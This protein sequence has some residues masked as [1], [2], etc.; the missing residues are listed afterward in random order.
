MGHNRSRLNDLAGRAAEDAVARA[1]EARGQRVLGRRWR[2]RGGEI[3]L[4]T[5]SNSEIVFVEVKKSSSHAKAA[6]RLSETQARRIM[7]AAEEYLGRFATG[8][9]TPMRI[10]LATVDR[11]GRVAFVENAVGEF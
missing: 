8:L 4:V 3:D 1:C 7:T 2:G 10:D 6:L 5:E 11:D 9:L